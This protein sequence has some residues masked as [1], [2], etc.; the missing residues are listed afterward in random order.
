MEFLA[1]LHWPLDDTQIYHLTE[2]IFPVLV[3]VVL[4][5][6]FR[7]LR[8]SYWVMILYSFLVPLAAPLAATPAA[9]DYFM[10]FSRYSLVIVPLYFG[11]VRLLR[12]RWLFWPYL[13][14]SALLLVVLTYMWA[15]GAWVA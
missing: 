6:S 14:L 3:L 13:I 12:R 1:R 8:P 7:K 5:A 10:S 9:S 2:L 4:V 15:S 11:L